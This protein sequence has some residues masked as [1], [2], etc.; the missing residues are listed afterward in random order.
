[1]IGLLAKLLRALMV[2]LAAAAVAVGALWALA[3]NE[4][5]TSHLLPMLPG[6]KV[7][8][9]Q[10]ALLGDF[11]AARVDISLPRYGR[12]T[13]IEPSWQQLQL[14][15][16]MPAAWRFGLDVA[17]LKARKLELVWVPDPVVKPLVAP[18]D[19]SLP[20]S[21]R[22]KRLLVDQAQSSLWGESSPL[23]KLDAAV[24]AQQAGQRQSS[25]VVKLAHLDWLNWSFQG[26]AQLGVNQG[27]S[28]L[29]DIQASQV[30]AQAGAQSGAQGTAKLH[31]QGPLASLQL[32]AQLSL[33]Q[34]GRAKQG[35]TLDGE[36]QPFAAWPVSR[37]TTSVQNLNLADLHASLPVSALQGQIS[38]QPTP[39]KEL[40]ARLD[41]RNEQ[42]GAWDEQ[43]LPLRSLRGH[44]LL[45]D[46]HAAKDLAQAWKQGDL[47]LVAQLPS[48]AGHAPGDLAV[49]GGWGGQ[50]TLQAQ[51]RKLEPQALHGLAPTLQLDGSLQLKPD[52]RSVAN[53][54]A[55]SDW[56]QLRSALGLKMTGLF[57]PS[58]SSHPA[59][60]VTSIKSSNKADIP[61]NLTLDG[62]YAPGQFEVS[63][64]R[65]QAQAA[66]AE[67]RDAVLRWALP[68]GAPAPGGAWAVKGHLK[69]QDFDPQVWLPWP[70]GMNGRNQLTG[71]MALALDAN[72]RGQLDLALQSSQLGGV[73]LNGQVQWR[74]P[75]APQ[76]MSLALDMSAAGN[77]MQ[78][79]ADLPW[80]ARAD[81]RPQLL[82]DANWQGTVHAP[83]LQA[84]QAV[85]PLI[86][87]RQLSGLVEGSF[88]GRGMW[89]QLNTDGQLSVSRLQWV[90]ANGVPMGLASGQ[91]AW[92]MDGQS[93]DAPLRLQLDLAQWQTAHVLLD[94][95]QWRVAG[96]LRQHESQLIADLIHK[97]QGGGKTSQVH[98]STAV[99]GGWQAQ[100]MSWQ[101]R[102]NELAIQLAGHTPRMLLQAQPFGLL[103]RDAPDGRS[104]RVEPTAL[105]VLGAGVRLNRLNWQAPASA[106]DPIGQLE[107]SLELEPLNL[108]ALLTSW[109][110]QAGWG[111]DLLLGGAL[112]LHHSARQPWVVDAYVARQSGDLSLSEPTIQGNSTQKLGIRDA[113]V[114]LQ[115]RD[116]VWT[117]TQQFDGRVLGALKG[118]Q[119]V[120]ARSAD[121]LPQAGDPLS[122]EL[123]M[124]IANLR[125][126]GTWVPAGWRLTGQMQAKAV[127]GGTLGV[128]HYTG[129]IKGQ[130]L[131]LGQA[132]MG[133]NL[134]DGQLLVDLEGEHVKLTQL[135]A[136]SGAQGGR[137]SAQGE[138]LLS[139]SP[140]AQLTVKAER[141]AL[142]QRVDRRVV[143]SGD[144]QASFNQD[145]IKVDGQLQVDEGLIDI[146]RSDAP[147]IGDDVNVLNR[148]GEDP[149]E[150]AEAVS[151]GNGGGVKRKLNA[152]V[153]VDL[154]HKHKLKGKG[155]DAFLA[156]KLRLTTHSNRPA[157]NGTVHVEN[158]TFAAY[159]Q[160]LV[161]E[162]GDVVFTGAIE[163][164]RLDIL[165]MRPQSPTASASDVKVGVNITGTAQDPRVRLFSD[166]S[167]SETEKLSWLVLGRGPTGLGGADIGLL[168]SAAV[169][170]LSG[171]GSSPSD[172]LVAMLGLDELSVRQTESAGS[173]VRDTVVN[174][175]KQ[176]SKYWYVGY[177]RNLNATSGNWQLIYRLAQ[178]FTVRAQAGDD[179]AVDFIWSWKW[180][181][182]KAE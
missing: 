44:V 137:I 166:P 126:W 139:E 142:L 133:L 131:G 161:I 115:A 70:A 165:A 1:M 5:A 118:R 7:S 21:L 61:V 28:L 134:T 149:E 170:L 34:E 98:L 74:S 158:G 173:T 23:Q 48:V 49:N 91:V 73:P 26:S 88:K 62:R 178:R 169:A 104:L 141:F 177:E 93:A 67:L 172:N 110:P 123:D 84:L 156:G 143:I 10:G 145:D 47:D 65:L 179:N 86:G 103:W 112:K 148:P 176:V 130:N 68:G 182:G 164:P 55:A 41:L 151:N 76:R 90:M 171:E 71:E 46:V 27:L 22:V 180:D 122:G 50:R 162:R 154:G 17:Q 38:L 25:H 92:S 59:K 56:A 152:N 20:F 33:Q 72:W 75:Q 111:G 13:L 11:Q 3:H 83:A 174:L 58:F 105:T 100:A 147:T 64:L 18:T 163:N 15:P 39:K 79:H 109:Q 95:A 42:A 167:M 128:P 114:A 96:S 36:L 82:P 32:Q 117:T 107:A 129:Q 181:Q 52:W 155:L 63:A 37:L 80:R 144:T 2:L 81:G 120:Q 87:L 168:Q 35:L 19:L 97:P 119:M 12:L 24:E 16:D 69:V 9:A 101:G 116:G 175:G 124:Q 30:Q 29:A 159:G 4:A 54:G 31:A 43:R 125:P 102:V 146:T 8:G 153:A 135:T 89:P 51:W 157:L 138:A 57:G 106:L 136:Q 108:P 60:S 113:R 94:K 132:L 85:V 66:Q 77:Q 53:K 160:K 40:E 121:V 150:Q 14:T 99:Q 127:L 78:A 6:I 45:P 140:Q